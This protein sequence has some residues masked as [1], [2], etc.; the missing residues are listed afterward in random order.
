MKY[1]L[2][3]SVPSAFAKIRRLN[4]LK[5]IFDNKVVL[6]PKEVYNEGVVKAKI[7]GHKIG[8]ELINIIASDEKELNDKWILVKQVKR[9]M[10]DYLNDKKIDLGEAEVI[11]LAKEENAIAVIDD[12]LNVILAE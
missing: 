6:I 12:Q 9:D 8:E 2:D 5:R 3:N 10:R 4:L 1:I 7:R 11:E